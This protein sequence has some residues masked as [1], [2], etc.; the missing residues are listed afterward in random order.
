[1]YTKISETRFT[2]QILLLLVCKDV[3][4]PCKLKLG[5]LLQSVRSASLNITAGILKI[6]NCYNLQQARYH[7]TQNVLLLFATDGSL[8]NVTSVI[9]TDRG[10][11]NC[12]NIL[13]HFVLVCYYCYLNA[14]S[15]FKLQNA[16]LQFAIGL[17]LQSFKGYVLLR[18]A[19]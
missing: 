10:V 1:M 3:Y 5:M 13:L 15:I 16:L 2:L 14:K 6:N 7:K 17:L 18:Q 12:D 11:T 8:Q 9:T 19:L 4:R